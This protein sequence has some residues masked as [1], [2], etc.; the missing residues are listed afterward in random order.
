MKMDSLHYTLSFGAKL[1]ESKIYYSD[2]KKWEGRNR[3][4]I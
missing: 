4:I 3:E 2:S 1:G